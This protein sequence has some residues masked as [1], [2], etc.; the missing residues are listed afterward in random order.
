G[1]VRG[2][3]VPDCRV[4]PWQHWL[5]DPGAV[6]AGL[7][8]AFG[9]RPLAIRSARHGEDS[10][11]G[12]AG[13]Y[14]SRRGVRGGLATATAVDEVFASYGCCRAGDAVLVQPMVRRVEHAVVASSRGTHGTAYDSVSIASGNAPGAITSGQA[15]ATTWHVLPAARA[16]ALPTLVQRTLALVDELRRLVP[17]TAFEVELLE[18]AGELW[19]LQ[20]RP[21]P[22]AQPAVA[23]VQAARRR[24]HRQLRRARHGGARLLGLMP[25][26]NPAELL[27]AHP[28][29]LAL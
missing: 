3:R 17:D 2:A 19:L 14:L 4:V 10:G 20:L 18:A 11:A 12:D 29:P 23:H 1:R 8:A 16:P 6:L 22:T 26:W 15:P 28:R 24:A 7:R 9:R 13:R 21:L 27:G 25:D 5:D